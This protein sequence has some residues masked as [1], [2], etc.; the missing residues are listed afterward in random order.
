MSIDLKNKKVSIIGAKRSGIATAD[1]VKL[2]GGIPF[3]S[4]NSPK[5]DE[6]S[7]AHFEQNGIQY[8]F[9]QHSQRIY[10]CDLMVVSPGVAANS[11]VVINAKS[12][13]ITVLPEIELA[14]HLCKGKI[15][16]IT[17]SNG[18]TTTTALIGEIFKNAGLPTYICGN[19][20]NPFI[21]IARDIPEN[22]FAIVELS[23]FQLELTD[24][25]HP[26]VAIFLN[27]TPDHLD[28][29]GNLET[30]INAKMKIFANQGSNDYAVLNLDDKTLLEKGSSL[31][32]K[33]IW[34]STVKSVPDGIWASSGRRNLCRE[35]GIDESPTKCRLRVNIIYPMPAPRSQRRCVLV[36][37]RIL[38]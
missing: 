18:K 6:Q 22:G 36:Y 10:D 15:I 16:G 23:S 33:T 28:R 5:K 20:G 19:I 13:K 32:S 2:L 4:D 14:Y 21:A 38:L 7:V 11:E 37:Q 34:F 25:F 17:G 30:Y 3:V 12:K 35:S 27:L 31:K 8:E 9:G 29:H 24:K 26:H 1:A